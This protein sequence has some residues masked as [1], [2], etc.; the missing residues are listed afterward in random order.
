MLAILGLMFFERR[1]KL[2]L[3]GPTYKKLFTFFA[4]IILGGIVLASTISIKMPARHTSTS[5]NPI[6]AAKNLA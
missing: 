1:L 5:S 4:V 2:V 3:S 6:T